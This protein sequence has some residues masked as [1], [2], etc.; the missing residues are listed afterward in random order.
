M[1]HHTHYRADDSVA[2]DSG[3]IALVVLLLGVLIIGLI[4]YR[5]LWA[6]QNAAPSEINNTVTTPSV[7]APD[8][9]A[10]GTTTTPG[11]TP[12]PGTTTPGTTTPGTATP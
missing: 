7:T 8:T 4:A 3:T 9:T 12:A 1:A 5:T 11:T 10:P 6:N 2:A